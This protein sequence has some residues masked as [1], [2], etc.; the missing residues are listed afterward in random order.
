MAI[1]IV[2]GVS[3]DNS[4]GQ[5]I[6]FLASIVKTCHMHLPIEQVTICGDNTSIKYCG[7]PNIDIAFCV[8]LCSLSIY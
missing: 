4:L 8:S 3:L 1:Y 6:T 5:R 7:L 2:E